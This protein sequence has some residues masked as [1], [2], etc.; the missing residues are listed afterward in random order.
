[1]RA[2]LTERFSLRFILVCRFLGYMLNIAVGYREFI[3]KSS[4]QGLHFALL[5]S[6]AHID[7]SNKHQC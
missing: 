4:L 2:N 3:S 6:H 5:A 7:R 1:M